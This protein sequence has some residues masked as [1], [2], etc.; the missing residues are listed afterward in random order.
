MDKHIISIKGEY[1]LDIT[2]TNM[3]SNISITASYEN[4]LTTEGLNFLVNKWVDSN[5]QIKE[6]IFGK[7]TEANR[8]DYTI[9][10]FNDPYIFTIK[11]HAEDNRLI[12]YQNNLSGKQVNNTT[13]IGVIGE[14]NGDDILLSRN[15]HPRI[16]VPET[17]IIK[18]KYIYSLTSKEEE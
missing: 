15:K 13:E 10:D 5:G 11:T 14:K 6:V 9:Q 1:E 2:Y 17:C 16:S 7:N 12:L 4:M 8:A 18:M 3:F